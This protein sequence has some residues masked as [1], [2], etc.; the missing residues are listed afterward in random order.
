MISKRVAQLNLQEIIFAFYQHNA[1]GGTEC[2]RANKSQILVFTVAPF[3]FFFCWKIGLLHYEGL[4]ITGN[5]MKESVSVDI[6]FYKSLV[7]GAG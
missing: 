6:T 3:F 4:C 7:D 5:I 2:D 1:L